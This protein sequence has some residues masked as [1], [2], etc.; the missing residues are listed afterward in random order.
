MTHSIDTGTSNS[1]TSA[2]RLDLKTFSPE[3]QEAILTRSVRKK[4]K[5]SRWIRF[6]KEL[7]DIDWR[8]EIVLGQIVRRMILIGCVLFITG[9]VGVLMVQEFLPWAIVVFTVSLGFG[10]V[11]GINLVKFL[12]LRK[13]DVA[14]DFRDLLLPLLEALEEDVDPDQRVRIDLDLRGFRGRKVTETRKL[15]PGRF[16]RL[17]LSTKVDPWLSLD[18]LLVDGLR[19]GV[20]IENHHQTFRRKYRTRRRK[21]KVKNKYKKLVFVTVYLAPN[22]ASFAFDEDGVDVLRES[23][24]IKLREKKGAPVC[25]LRRKFKLGTSPAPVEETIDS[26]EVIRMIMTLSS[27]L[28]PVQKRS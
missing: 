12:K 9:M 11:F 27:R 26:E 23:N 24:K 4:Q 6:L 1:E 16:I 21:V 25:F 14:N 3:I 20:R 13:L 17:R 18:A 10:V 2:S 8:A 19:L 15:P 28:I 7:A 5:I 22:T